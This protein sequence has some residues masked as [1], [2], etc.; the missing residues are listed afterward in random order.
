[1][2]SNIISVGSIV[3]ERE[4]FYGSKCAIVCSIYSLT[5]PEKDYSSE[6]FNT[7]CLLTGT[8]VISYK[9]KSVFTLEK[10]GI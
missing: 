9:T 8:G 2:S 10:V 1:M 4:P 7:S 3:F 5:K 6:I